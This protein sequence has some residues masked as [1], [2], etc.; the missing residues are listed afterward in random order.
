MA[1]GSRKGVMFC[2]KKWY[3]RTVSDSIRWYYV[4]RLDSGRL[5]GHSQQKPSS[6]LR[7]NSAT[8]SSRI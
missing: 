8:E 6:G 5:S 7:L 2:R 1:F 4:P 3:G